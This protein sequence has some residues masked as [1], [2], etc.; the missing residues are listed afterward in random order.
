M[1]TQPPMTAELSGL[2]VEYAVALLY[3]SEAGKREA[4]IAFDVGEGTQDLG[5]RAEVP[6]LFDVRPAANVKLSRARSS[7]A[8]RRPGAFFSSITRATFFRRR[9]SGSRPISFSRSRSI[10]RTAGRCSLPPGELT[11]YYGR[12]PEYRWTQRK[13]Q[14]PATGAAEIAVQLE[15]WIDPSRTTAS[16]AAIITSTRR[17][18]RTTP[19]RP[20][21]CGRRTCFA[22]V[23]GEGLNVGCVLSWGY[24]FDYPAA[25]LRDRQATRSASRSR[26]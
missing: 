22:Q 23:K 2:R 14:V 3:G 4:T 26:C 7:T 19:R 20:K 12:G 21:A 18:A 24:G 17:A 16:T 25:V 1:F 5:F 11:M 6:V 9:P 15:R 13:I 8:S 10:A